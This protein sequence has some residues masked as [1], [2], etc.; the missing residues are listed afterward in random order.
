MDTG[1]SDRI[2][3]VLKEK[4]ISQK[5]F[6][7]QSGIPE[8]TISDWKKKGNTP[9]AESI[10]A[11]CRTLEI[12]VYDLLSDGTQSEPEREPDY[13]LSDSEKDLIERYRGLDEKQKRTVLTYFDKLINRISYDEAETEK[14]QESAD[15]VEQIY[16]PDTEF[17]L[18]KQL[19][20]RLRKL[21]RLSRIRLDETEHA[22][23][24]NL[25]LFK[26]L[27]YLGM[28]KLEYVKSYLSN[29]QPFM[30]TE[31]RSQEKFENAVCVLDRI[32]RISVYIKV[33]TT[34]G[35]EIVVSFHE[36]N[37]GGVAHKNPLMQ[38]NNR[39]YVFADSIGS[40]VKGTDNYSIN[41]FITRGVRTFPIN[42]PANKYDDEG[43]LVR[44]TYIN[45]ALIDIMNG[46]LEDLYTADLDFGEINA[47]S[48]LQQL[49]FTSFGNDV[50]SN[51]SLLVDSMIIQ[52]DAMSRQVAD[53]ALVIYCDSIEM[54]DADKEE[55][56]STLKARYQV[57]SECAL[58]DIIERIEVSIRKQLI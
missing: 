1:I 54:T 29:I 44:Y 30:L 5:E 53:A 25:H 11:I 27:D 58:P 32:Y 49:S 46:Y 15:T 17:L 47:F 14:I 12:P 23:R 13:Y 52:R 33:D 41:L 2:F 34:K 45:N 50:F 35:E 57:N 18:Q 22:S 9:K 31:M 39:V 24:L 48:S 38:K 16:E 56:I 10:L 26:Y 37:K 43:F 8:S 51:I 19:A 6:S 20:R 3:A 7:R 42:V 36:N 28:D 21:A 40:H 4:G 55:L